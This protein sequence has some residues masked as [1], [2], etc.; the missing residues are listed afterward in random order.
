MAGHR[1]IVM[2][3]EDIQFALTRLSQHDL[4]RFREW[5]HE[6]EVEILEENLEHVLEEKH[7]LQRAEQAIHDFQ[8][9][10]CTERLTHFISP[11]FLTC[12]AQLPPDIQ[13]QADVR[14]DLLKKGQE[15]PSSL[16]LKK[17]G[18]FWF[19][20]IATGYQALAVETDHCLIWFWIGAYDE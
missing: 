19:V 8:A 1:Q 10:R 2:K 3:L 4:A 12:Y 15:T 17:A 13:E 11:D 6:F 14:I 9:G 7:V 18:R 16:H 20:R 5:Y